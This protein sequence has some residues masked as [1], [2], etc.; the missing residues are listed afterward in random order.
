MAPK[1]NMK[2]Y[3][4]NWGLKLLKNKRGLGAPI[5]IIVDSVLLKPMM[6]LL[7]VDNDGAMILTAFSS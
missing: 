1:D 2:I 3:S 5:P 4:I 6:A 7:S